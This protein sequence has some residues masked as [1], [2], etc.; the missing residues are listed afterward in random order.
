MKKLR[1]CEKQPQLQYFPL[2]DT[3]LADVIICMNETIEEESNEYMGGETAGESVT[4]QTVYV[5]DYNSFRTTLDKSVIEENLNFYINYEETEMDYPKEIED[6]KTQ[7]L[8]AQ[9][10]L[11]SIYEMMEASV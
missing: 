1:A 4:P 9:M 6:L 5:Y 3:D 11:C 8:D 2:P 10:A 7:V